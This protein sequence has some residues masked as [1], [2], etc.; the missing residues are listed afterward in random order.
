MLSATGAA[1][2]GVSEAESARG[3]SCADEGWLCRKPKAT[4]ITMRRQAAKPA[5]IHRTALPFPGAA[6]WYCARDCGG[7]CAGNESVPGFARL[8]SRMIARRYY[9][10]VEEASVGTGGFAGPPMVFPQVPQKE[11]SS[12]FGAPQ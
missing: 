10:R 5:R 2:G 11:A 12:G 6:G 9:E 1:A 4:A 3:A 7:G 8:R